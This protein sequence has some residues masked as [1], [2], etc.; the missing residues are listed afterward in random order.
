MFP[1]IFGVNLHDVPNL[2]SVARWRV[3]GDDDSCCTVFE[4]YCL[5]D[6]QLRFIEAA[7]DCLKWRF[8]HDP[9]WRNAWCRWQFYSQIGSARQGSGGDKEDCPDV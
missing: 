4:V 3:P 7:L 8:P 6:L 1:A 5:T 9:L 2:V